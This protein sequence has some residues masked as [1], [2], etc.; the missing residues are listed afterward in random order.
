MAGHHT[1]RHH[2]ERWIPLERQCLSQSVGHCPGH[3]RH[4][5]E[6]APLLRH[7]RGEREPAGDPPCRL[8]SGKRPFDV[9]S[10]PANPPSTGSNKTS[11]HLMPSE[12]L[13]KHI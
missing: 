9:L 7:A 3:H 10:I 4:Q 13:R 8:V 5:L 11:T 2:R 6:W 12:K 1:S